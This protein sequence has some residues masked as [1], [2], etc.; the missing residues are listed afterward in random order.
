MRQD[1]IF[2][3]IV[4]GKAPGPLIYQ[5][6]DVSAFRDINPQAPVHILLVPNKHIV[7]INQAT[8]EDEVILGKLMLAAAK[9]AKA[10][11]IADRGYR[12]LTN[13]G[14]DA[15]QA[16]FHLHFHLLAGRRL[17]WPPG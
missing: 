16:V 13:T 4:A 11:G 12:L 3:Q 8:E 10:E 6:E 14:P 5:D 17:T 1:C 7:S 2:C 15:G 9:V